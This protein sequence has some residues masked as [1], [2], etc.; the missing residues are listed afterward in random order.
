MDA[1]EVGVVTVTLVRNAQEER[2][3]RRALERLA[4]LGLPVAAA[5]GGSGESFVRFL[6]ELGFRVAKPRKRGLVPQVKAGVALGAKSLRREFLLYTEPDKLLFFEGALLDF[7][8]QVRSG[9]RFGMALAARDAAG[10]ASFPGWQQFTESSMNRV[11]ADFTGQP[12]DYCY[13]PLLFR[14]ADADRVR[15]APDELGWGVA[16]FS[17]GRAAAGEAAGRTASPGSGMPA[18]A[19]EGAPHRPA[20]SDPP[21]AAEPGWTAAGAGRVKGRAPSD[22]LFAAGSDKVC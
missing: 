8:H 19:T 12:G 14:A 2:W 21:T 17:A 9:S 6:K 20:I 7:I 11:T 1:A 3:M 22:P 4:G 10:F 18:G 13:G 16:V 15:H 5:D